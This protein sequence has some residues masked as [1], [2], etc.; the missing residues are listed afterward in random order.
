MLDPL[1]LELYTHEGAWLV[2]WVLGSEVQSSLLH[3]KHSY[4]LTHLSIPLRL[5]TRPQEALDGDRC[6][7]AASQ[8]V[9]LVTRQGQG[10]PGGSG[11]GAG[12]P[13]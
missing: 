3:S 7:R 12:D 13:P 11:E 4:S 10:V 6:L 2:T 5:N 9:F 1:E 8:Q